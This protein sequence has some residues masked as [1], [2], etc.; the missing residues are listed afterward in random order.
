L[1]IKKIKYQIPGIYTKGDRDIKVAKRLSENGTPY[2]LI[3]V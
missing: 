3:A 2:L 1:I